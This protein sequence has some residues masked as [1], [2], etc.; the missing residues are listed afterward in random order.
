MGLSLFQA[1]FQIVIVVTNAYENMDKLISQKTATTLKTLMYNKY[2][3]LKKIVVNLIKEAI[4]GQCILP[5][6]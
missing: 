1:P 5:A 3:V 2:K 4:T 6:P